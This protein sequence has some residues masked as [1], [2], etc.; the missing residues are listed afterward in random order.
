MSKETQKLW[1]EFREGKAT[2]EEVFNAVIKELSNTE[3]KVKANQTAVGI[4]GTQ[5]EDLEAEVVAALDTSINK[6]GEFE[7]ATEKA[8]EALSDTKTKLIKEKTRE[9]TASFEEA[10]NS[11]LYFA[12]VTGEKQPEIAETFNLFGANI[13]S[14]TKE[15][16]GSFLELSS[17]ATNQM[18]LL[19]SSV[20][21]LSQETAN[22]VAGIYETMATQVR[23]AIAA[24]Q[25]ET[26]TSMSN[27]FAT[28]SALSDEE[29]ANALAKMTSNYET[30][31]QVI[32]DG[33]KRAIEI[34]T[35]AVNEKRSI[36]EEE[37]IELNAIRAQMQSQAID[38]MSA[39]E[40]EQKS[41]LERLKVESS[42]ITAQQAASVVQN[43]LKQKNESVKAAEEQYNQTVQEI[44]RQR[45]ET[46]S[47]TAEQATKLIGEAKRQK[48]KSVAEAQIMH[49]DV[50]KEAKAQA[51]EHVNEID[52]STGKMLTG[53][54]QF[55][56]DVKKVWDGIYKDIKKVINDILKFIDGIEFKLPKFELPEMPHFSLKTASKTVMGKKIS[57][58]S[59]FDVDWYDKGG[60]FSGPT[61]I[62]VGEKRPEFVGALDDLRAIVRDEM[63]NVLKV[64][65]PSMVQASSIKIEPAPVHI[66]GYQVA[67]VIFPHVNTKM[68]DKLSSEMVFRGLKR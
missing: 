27:F 50:V 7:G 20:V 3:D 55:K 9:I 38:I 40:A 52:W 35:T 28:T 59:G 24:R 65:D 18:S 1:K 16:I 14:K 54:D 22:E 51:K 6:L 4:F 49:R 48:E 43:S 25:E 46:G 2:G 5:W 53:Y 26:L 58:P 32:T 37:G 23:D 61:I 68:G 10:I 67:E 39:S 11:F 57:Y 64:T 63:S 36:T 19:K 21:P 56:R 42:N 15:A 66:D 8:G 33:E 44:I 30:R 41:I 13:S 60:V 31:S 47:I 62:G 12:L 34:I 17:E 45:D 29:E